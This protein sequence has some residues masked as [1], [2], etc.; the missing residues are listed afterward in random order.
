MKT[1]FTVAELERGFRLGRWRVQPQGGVLRQPWPRRAQRRIEPKVMQVL[2]ELA[3]RP[4]HF[5]SK[6]ELFAAIWGS[7]PSSDDRLTRAVH[8]LRQALDDDPQQP[9]FI[10]TRSNVGYRLIA[11]VRP[12]GAVVRSPMLAATIAAV[13][14]AGAI[15]VARP[16]ADGDTT[17]RAAAGLEESARAKFLQARYWLASG[18]AG[19]LRSALAAF[20][21]LVAAEPDFAPGWLGQA[22]ARLELFKQGEAGVEDLRRARASAERALNLAGP[23]PALALCLGQLRLFLEW[24]LA[25]AESYYQDAIRMDP[26]EPVAR[27]RYS[28]LLV[29]RGDFAAAATQ[30]EQVRLLD[31]LYYASPDMAAL[32]LYAGQVDAAIA[33]LERLER[34]TNLQPA[35]LRILGTAY[36]IRGNREAAHRA[37]IR[38]WE[39]TSPL[40]SAA[41]AELAA[42]NSTLLLRRILAED[43]AQSP[44]ARASI[45]ALL[46]DRDEALAALE[47]AASRRAPQLLF[48]RAM[49]EFAALH[50]DPRFKLLVA[51]LGLEPRIPGLAAGPHIS[52]SSLG[53]SQALVRKSDSNSE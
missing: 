36:W 43:V 8:A 6:D 12:A 18:D 21:E 34:T 39:A 50:A 4:Q 3:A 7:R 28:W 30:I 35:V 47:L 40:S 19:S 15:I 17:A 14:L 10:E 42:A 26:R 38:M 32:L 9:R 48:V 31:P 24:D 13:V 2:V 53:K 41:R 23:G 5:L 51:Q 16:A 49:P 52:P 25:G 33:E 11:P 29:A 46:G 22:Q 20:G 37:F 45:H 27:I 1:R 44:V